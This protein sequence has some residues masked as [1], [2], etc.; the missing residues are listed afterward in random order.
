MVVI[1]EPLH[2]RKIVLPS[3]LKPFGMHLYMQTIKNNVCIEID[4]KKLNIAEN[5]L[6]WRGETEN[7]HEFENQ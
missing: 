5:S 4:E 7:L 2:F 1:F 6:D 3:L